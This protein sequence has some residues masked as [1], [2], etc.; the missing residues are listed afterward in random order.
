MHRLEKSL[1]CSDFAPQRATLGS[2]LPICRLDPFFDTCFASSRFVHQHETSL[3]DLLKGIRLRKE[4]TNSNWHIPGSNFKVQVEN[5]LRMI[6][7][8]T[9]WD[10]YGL[11]LLAKTFRYPIS[12][13][14]WSVNALLPLLKHGSNY[15]PSEGK[16]TSCKPHWPWKASGCVGQVCRNP[17]PHFLRIYL[18]RFLRC[19]SLAKHFRGTV[20]KTTLTCWHLPSFIWVLGHLSRLVKCMCKSSTHGWESTA[21]VTCL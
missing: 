3:A 1:H 5:I 2:L 18:A 13:A 21:P 12:L 9:T 11:C 15:L 14:P 19:P 17:S 10:I 20:W 4:N 6:L 7:Y 8:Y 16:L